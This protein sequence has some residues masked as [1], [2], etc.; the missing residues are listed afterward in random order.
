MTAPAKARRLDSL[1]DFAIEI[2]AGDWPPAADLESLARRAVSATLA[3]CA[4]LPARRSELGLTFTDDANIAVLNGEWRGK[5]SPTNVLSFPVVAMRPG[6]PLP[7]LLGDIV[8]AFETVEREAR[9]QGKPFVNHLTHLLVH[10]LLH[11]LGHDHMIDEAA[12]E[13]E[14]LERRILERLAIPDPYA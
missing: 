11:L 2:E 14:T 9:E 1:L 12:H 8:L 7:E 13:M 6:D 5:A 10:G 3:Q 4:I